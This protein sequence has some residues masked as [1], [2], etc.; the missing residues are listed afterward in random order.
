MLYFPFWGQIYFLSAKKCRHHKLI[1]L[2]YHNTRKVAGL[3]S[4]TWHHSRKY[5]QFCFTLYDATASDPASYFSL[6]YEPSEGQIWPSLTLWYIS[7][8]AQCSFYC[9]PHS[10]QAQH[11]DHAGCERNDP[12]R[13]TQVRTE[14]SKDQWCWIYGRQSFICIKCPLISKVWGSVLFLKPCFLH[15]K[16]IYG[17]VLYTL[18][19]IGAQ[20]S[21]EFWKM[22]HNLNSEP[23]LDFNLLVLPC[24]L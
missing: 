20:L 6:R 11:P 3:L 17:T 23:L 24:A 22:V 7:P 16:S 15:I 13:Q 14:P 4:F 9:I 5:M 10:N 12:L 19:R 1:H 8:F 2:P 18:D 21:S